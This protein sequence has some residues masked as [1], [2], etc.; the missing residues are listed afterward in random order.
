M[1][2]EINANHHVSGVHSNFFINPIRSRGSLPEYITYGPN[3]DYI[4]TKS[5]ISKY[6]SEEKIREM[7]KANPKVMEMLIGAGIPLAVNMKTLNELVQN[8]MNETRKVSLGIVNNLPK[9][10]RESV[11]YDALQ[12]AAILHDFGKVLIPQNILNKRGKLNEKELSIIEMHSQLSHELL[13]T[14]DLDDDTLRLIK[15]HHQNAHKTG[16]PEV[17]DNYVSDISTQILSTADMYTA[18]REKRP[19]KPEMSKDQALSII[20]KDMKQGKIHPYVFKALVDYANRQE[21]LA[22]INP[23]RQINNLESIYGLSA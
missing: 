19:Y 17:E 14:T 22:N 21:K 16:Y 3:T 13:K 11:N 23:Q 12:K 2:L 8:H 10:F 18:L 15:Y 6:A 20:H 1:G 7:I 4:D 9:D 5:A